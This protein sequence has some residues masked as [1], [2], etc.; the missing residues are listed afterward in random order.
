MAVF[1]LAE[2]P[3]PQRHRLLTAVIAPRPIALVSSCDA[4]G[5][6]NLAPFSYFMMGGTNPASCAVSPTI[7]RARGVKD[8]LRNIRETGEYTISIV[9]RPMME[10]V[11]QASFD[12]S[13][14]VDE[15]DAAG[16]TRAP[17]TLVR[18]PRVAE[19]PLALE[20]RL[21]AVVA[22]GDQPGAAN[23]VIG[24]VLRIHADDAVLAPD[25]F[26]DIRKVEP[27]SRLGGADWGVTRAD[28]MLSLARPT[29]G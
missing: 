8:T 26:P 27:M 10:R 22:H 11:N 5:R 16:L 7:D 9:T 17:S 14:E 18:P 21:F 12:Y 20:C 6:G 29:T 23:Y 3:V 2:L 1:R 13:P 15:F 4:A 25:G 24:E 28:T 19:S